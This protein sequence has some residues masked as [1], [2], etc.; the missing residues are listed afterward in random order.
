MVDR[1]IINPLEQMRDFDFVSFEHDVVVGL[2]YAMQDVMSQLASGTVV[3]GFAASAAAPA[4]LVINLSAGRI[5]TLAYP[6]PTGI[7]SIAQD[8]GTLVC[9]QGQA[10]GQALTLTPPSVGQSQWNLIQIQ[11]SVNDIVRPGDPNGGLV[12]FYNSTNPLI[13][14]TAS[15]A[16]VRRHQAIIQVIQGAAAQT[17]SEV[18]PTPTVGWTPLYLI[19]LAGGQTQITTPQIIP[20]GPSVGTNVPANYPYAPFLAGLLASH[21]QGT[22]GQ[23]PKINLAKE[24]TGILPVANLP[25]SVPLGAFPKVRTLLTQNTTYYVATSGSDT[26]GN[27]SAATPWATPQYA[28]N[29]I[30]ANLDFDGYVVTMAV[31]P[32]N[33]GSLYVS[34][35]HAGQVTGGQYVI[36]GNGGSPV[37]GAVN[38]GAGSIQTDNGARISINNL[39]CRNATSN[40]GGYTLT[41]A[42]LLASNCSG[43]VI[44]PNVTFGPCGLYQLFAA[45]SSQISCANSGI[46]LTITGGGTSLAFAEFA[47]IVDVTL[48][49]ITFTTAV[50]YSA[51][52]ISQL[53]G[54]VGLY[55]ATFVNPGNVT[56][57]K[58]S[59]SNAG[60][61]NTGGAG[62]NYLP[63]SVAGTNAGGYYL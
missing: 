17:G 40:A 49:V 3:A 43:I 57:P 41:G 12:P 44:G 62:I 4:S 5:Y 27:G 55:G 48:A 29:W 53:S 11:F 38:P 61:V 51:T 34:K 56:G 18:P 54:Y 31:A 1:S 16:T 8:Q 23:A 60:A 2:G 7:G 42:G 30:A 25:A 39:T 26:T 50:S 28:Q 24:V 32:G 19:D 6:D 10:G 20:A 21:H 22:P 47:G 36:Q 14:N 45:N 58:F 15:I 59:V 37:F 13:P 63:G 9:L 35:M 52:V 46:V 33:Y